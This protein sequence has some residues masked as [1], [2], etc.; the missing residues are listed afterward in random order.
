MQ[1]TE[2]LLNGMSHVDDLLATMQAFSA[3][4]MSGQVP[5]D[6]FS[7]LVD[8]EQFSTRFLNES[9]LVLGFPIDYAIEAQTSQA[10]QNSAIWRFIST[11]AALGY[12]GTEKPTTISAIVARTMLNTRYVAMAFGNALGKPNDNRLKT[13]GMSKFSKRITRAWLSNTD[14]RP[15]TIDFMIPM[16][17]W[18]ISLIT[19]VVDELI[20]LSDQLCEHGTLTDPEI[21]HFLYQ[22][23]GYNSLL[24]YI[25]L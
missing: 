21:P 2:T 20:I 3:Q 17:S 8:P 13:P 22:T 16:A 24:S 9:Y 25:D 14:I 23:S 18:S 7:A 6:P 19:F 10:V 1:Y 15:E 5:L 4:I 12:A 11:Q